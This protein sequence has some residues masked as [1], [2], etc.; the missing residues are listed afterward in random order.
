VQ[1]E[2]LRFIGVKAAV[3]HRQAYDRI[4]ASSHTVR[5]P[6][7]CTSDLPSLPYRNI[8]PGVFPLDPPW[9]PE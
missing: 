1:P 3:A 5:T 7:P 6:G 8:R 4:A 9:R 2:A